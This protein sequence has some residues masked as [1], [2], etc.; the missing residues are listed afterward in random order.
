[1]RRLLGLLGVL[2]ATP[3]AGQQPATGEA[4]AIVER[5][6]RTW[7]DLT[8]LQA[9]FRMRSE[10]R[11][12]GNEESRGRLLQR[13]PKF[14]M[15]FQNSGF[16][17]LDG[18]SEYSYLP[19][20]VKGQVTQRPAPASAV[21]GVNYVAWFLENPVEKYTISYLRSESIDGRVMDVVQMDPKSRDEFD[22]R[23]AIVWFDRGDG[24]PRRFDLDRV[25]NRLVL[26]L[27]RLQLNLAIADSVFRFVRPPNTK[28]VTP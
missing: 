12:I 13:G 5:A 27:S 3:L 10:D 14:L 15:R 24:L 19:D 18:V 20:V 4:R 11:S 9:D 28:V 21:H 6:A 2:L 8:S 22:F 16:Y 17:L 26:D 25:R 7:R 1:M 23:R